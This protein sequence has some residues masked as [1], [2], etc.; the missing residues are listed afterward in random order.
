[1]F[2]GSLAELKKAT[3]G[4]QVV[5]WLLGDRAHRDKDQHCIA[6]ITFWAALL[7]F[8][9]VHCDKVDSGAPVNHRCQ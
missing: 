8:I 1:M 6:S 9:N 4:V 3:G 5:R 7:T 2:L